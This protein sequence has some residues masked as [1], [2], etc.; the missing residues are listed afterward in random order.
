M[1]ERANG[2]L[3]VSVIVCMS[4]CARVCVRLFRVSAYIR[5]VSKFFLIYFRMTDSSRAIDVR[6]INKLKQY[7]HIDKSK[8]KKECRQNRHTNWTI[9][10]RSG[11]KIVYLLWNWTSMHKCRSILPSMCC[12]FDWLCLSLCLLHSHSNSNRWYERQILPHTYICNANHMS[13]EVRR[14]VYE[15]KIQTKNM[16]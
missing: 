12:W 11:R 9:V 6:N 2:E 10:C 5:A 13:W 7:S 15:L 16:Y 3:L 14:D 4:E 1:C 8:G